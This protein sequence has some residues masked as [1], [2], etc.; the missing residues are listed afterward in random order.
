MFK[1]NKG[2]VEGTARGE[3]AQG[4]EFLH[5]AVL[6]SEQILGVLHAVAVEQRLE[7]AAEVFVD[8]AGQV[9]GVRVEHLAQAH[10]ADV[11]V[12]VNLPLVQEKTHV[13]IEH[14]YLGGVS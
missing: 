11:L 1:A 2:V 14:T 10:Q 6:V 13:V 3:A 12:Q 5:V 7:V 8:D 9:G 4:G